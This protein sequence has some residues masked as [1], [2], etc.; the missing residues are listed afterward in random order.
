M[1]T[2]LISWI[3]LAVVAIHSEEYGSELHLEVE[4]NKHLT[5]KPEVNNSQTAPVFKQ[6]ISTL[7]N[8]DPKYVIIAAAFIC[9]LWYMLV[10]A[11]PDSVFQVHLLCAFQWKIVCYFYGEE[12][13]ELVINTRRSFLL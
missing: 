6:I 3:T 12:L 5:G 1:T 4:A 11:F 13:D 10:N 8:Y 2:L 7:S 9:Q